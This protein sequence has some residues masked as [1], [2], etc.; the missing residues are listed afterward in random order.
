MLLIGLLLLAAAAAFAII[1]IVSNLTGGPDYS[2][3]L[4]GGH[5][6]TV[7]TL[8]AF[9]GGIALALIFGLGLWLILGGTALRARRSRKMRNAQRE[10]RDAVSERDEMRS[11]LEGTGHGQ[12]ADSESRGA[13]LKPAARAHR[14]TRRLH[15]RGH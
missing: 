2:V 8:G 12:S 6:F 4:F 10:A 14:Q 1:L 9:C 7:S 15:L 13:T 3:S 11:Q 5:P